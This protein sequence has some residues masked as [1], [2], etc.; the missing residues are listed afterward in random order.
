MWYP[1]DDETPP[2]A[3]VFDEDSLSTRNWHELRELLA[4]FGVAHLWE[5]RGIVSSGLDYE[6][7]LAL[8]EPVDVSLDEI[9]W[10]RVLRVVHLPLARRHGHDRRRPAPERVASGMA[11]VAKLRPRLGLEGANWEANPV[12]AFSRPQGEKTEAPRRSQG[13]SRR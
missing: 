2:D 9:F 10:R 5:L 1:W 12:S 4:S 13:A 3:Q 7:E 8:L 6:I 11:G